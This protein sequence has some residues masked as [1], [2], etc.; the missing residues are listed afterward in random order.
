MPFNEGIGFL[1]WKEEE[2]MYITSRLASGIDYAFYEKA[3]NGINRVVKTITINGG[4]DV[5]NKKTLI[6]P[7]GVVTEIS[8]ADL[9]E[10]MQ[11]PVFKIHLENGY[12]SIN[13][14]EKVAEKA[15]EKLEKDKSSQLTEEDYENGNEKKEIIAEPKKKPKTK[16][17]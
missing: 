12:I 10:L 5:I 9:D 1:K 15:G 7:L 6:T 4:S 3:P 8:K 2:T 14:N 16:K 17:G 11:H 13:E